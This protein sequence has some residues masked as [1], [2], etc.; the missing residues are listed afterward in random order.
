MLGLDWKT[1]L[2]EVLNFF[3]AKIGQKE[4]YILLV[5]DEFAFIFLI[6]LFFQGCKYFFTNNFYEVN[7]ISKKKI[8]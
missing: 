6:T 7:L 1:K 4:I 5:L 3:K 8:K 2:S